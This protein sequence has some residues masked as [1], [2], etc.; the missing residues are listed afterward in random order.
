MKKLSLYLIT[1]ML[2]AIPMLQSCD[3]DGYSLGDFTVRMATIHIVNGDTYYLEIDN[4]QKLWPAATGIPWYKPVDGQRVWADYTLLSDEIP[5]TEYAHAIKVNYL[6]NVLTK[7]VDELTA[8]NEE[9]IGNDPAYIED[10]WIGGNYL[11]VQFLINIPVN[12]LH[13]VS[14][15]ENTLTG[16]PLID[17]EGYIHLE[18]RFNKADDVYSNVRRSYVSFNLG[19]YGPQRLTDNAI[20]GLKVKINSI[21]NGEKDIVFEYTKDNTEKAVTLGND[22]VNEGTK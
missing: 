5:E 16:D 21:K 4:G 9:E 3:D 14:L 7:T 10:M 22:V 20:K 19:E 2:I 15:V 6:F 18:Y 13:R 8:E 17:E 1:M 11:N 12:E